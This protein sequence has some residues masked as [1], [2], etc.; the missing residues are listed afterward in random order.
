MGRPFTDVI[1]SPVWLAVTARSCRLR[2]RRRRGG[3]RHARRRSGTSRPHRG[4]WSS[5]LSLSTRRRF[6]GRLLLPLR[7]H[8]RVLIGLD[9]LPRHADACKR[10]EHVEPDIHILS[11]STI[12]CILCFSSWWKSIIFIYILYSDHIYIP[13]ASAE[14]QRPAVALNTPRSLWE[15]NLQRKTPHVHNSI[16]LYTQERNGNNIT[17][18]ASDKHTATSTK[19]L[20]PIHLLFHTTRHKSQGDNHIYIEAAHVLGCRS[21]FDARSNDIYIYARLQPSFRCAW[22]L[23]K[24]HPSWGKN[25]RPIQQDTVQR[26]YRHLKHPSYI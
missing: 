20:S 9:L 22:H 1:F 24:V 2:R 13:A 11:W 21:H 18:A 14:R 6:C 3:L 4:N 26:V 7:R 23:S 8:V 10:E 19:S 12:P 15:P 25:P 5:A 17:Y 16:R